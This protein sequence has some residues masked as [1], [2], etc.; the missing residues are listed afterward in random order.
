MIDVLI[1]LGSALMVYNIW[2]FVHFAGKAK[3]QNGWQNANFILYV[4]IVLLT[5]FLAGYLAVG[6]FGRP[7]IIVSGILF[8]GSVFVCVMYILMERITKRIAQH[9]HLEAKLMAAEESNRAKTV[10]LSGVSHEMRTP[11]NVIIGL[12]TLALTNKSLPAETK[13]HI[14]KATHSAEQILGI[15]NNIIDL[16]SMETGEFITKADPFLLRDAVDQIGAIIESLCEEKGLAYTCEI[17]PDVCRGF[18]GD[19]MRLKQVLFN[20]L[21]NAVKYTDAPGNVRLRVSQ[22]DADDG[23]KAVAFAVED[24]GCGIDEIFLEHIFDAFS[25]EDY[26]ATSTHGGSGLGLTVSKSIVERLGGTLTVQS[27][28]GVGST[29]TAVIPLMPNETQESAAQEDAVSLE[30]KRILLAEDIPENAEIVMDLLE[31]EGAESEHAVNGQIAVDM[32]TAAEPGY[33]DAILMD[34]RMPVMDGITAAKTI[35]MANKA[36][37]ATIPIIALTANA[38]ESDVKESLKAGMN[39]HLSKPADTDKLYATLRRCIAD[40]KGADQA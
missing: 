32:F 9:E 21:D 15:V 1:Y 14:E 39:A 38:L 27:K 28:K 8:G 23:L 31:L 35:R 16:N 18:V 19:D 22:H 3:K 10:F 12:N 26:T 20:L 7:D 4:P 2:G 29:F 17:A 13:Q 6:F 37:A 25:K 40:Y 11:L 36:D 30:G 33:Y 34:L 5:L 24:T